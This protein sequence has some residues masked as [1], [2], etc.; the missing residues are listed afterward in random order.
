MHRVSLA[1]ARS[2][3]SASWLVAV[4]PGCLDVE[5]VDAYETKTLPPR[6]VIDD[7]DDD[8]DNTQRQ[9]TDP[10]FGSWHCSVFSAIGQDGPCSP[11]P[12]IEGTMGREIKFDLLEPAN[13]ALVYPYVELATEAKEPQDFS[14]YERFVLSA[15][16]QPS[17]EAPVTITLACTLYCG[18]LGS[19]AWVEARVLLASDGDWHTYERRIAATFRQPDWQKVIWLN[20]GHQLDPAAC[21]QQ[22]DA[23]GIAL[24][25]DLDGGERARGA[26][27]LD[28]I[29][30]Q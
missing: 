23:L 3:L 7:F 6:R 4:L 15:R 10:S 5:Q 18:G 2:I 16:L 22:V 14:H 12:G 29:Y 21:I 11:G 13:N 27:Y 20:D 19:D 8:V 30:V 28:E 17:R 25:P 9:P 1:F 24:S 26:L